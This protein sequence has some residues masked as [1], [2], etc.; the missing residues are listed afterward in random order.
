[1]EIGKPIKLQIDELRFEDLVIKLVSEMFLE[2]KNI[3]C[4]F[5]HKQ[6]VFIDKFKITRVL[7]NILTNAIE[8]NK[9][10]GKIWVHT[11]DIK[12]NKNDYIEVKIGNDGSYIPEIERLKLFDI[13]YTKNK[14]KGTGLGLT[15]CKKIIEIHKGKIICSSDYMLGTEFIFTLPC[16][17]I[18][19][20]N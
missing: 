13:F 1:M 3:S 8:A 20:E 9:N 6:E 4:L 10:K 11:K 17:N 15:I 19:N 16:F 18:N 5:D 7:V 14:K 12:M 2:N